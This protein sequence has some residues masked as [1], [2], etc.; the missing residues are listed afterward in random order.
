MSPLTRTVRLRDKPSAGVLGTIALGVLSCLVVFADVP[1]G[2]RMW[3]PWTTAAAVVALI[4][5][6]T[7][8]RS[9]PIGAIVA[10]VALTIVAT[11]AQLVDEAGQV[12][13]G[14][15]A[16]IAFLIADVARHEPTPVVAGIGMASLVAATVTEGL[17]DDRGLGDVVF[18]AMMWAFA[19][20]T[21][22]AIRWRSAATITRDEH[23]RAEE[24]ER[25]AREL[26]DVVAHH[27]AA[28]ALTAE[29]ARTVVDTDT[30]RVDRS[31]A[32][33]NAAAS[34]AL[35]EMHTMVS[36]LRDSRGSSAPMRLDALADSLDADEPLR[37]C[38]EVEPECGEPSAA[39]T[40][41]IHRIAQE[42]VT[43]CR[44][45]AR[46]A[47]EVAVNVRCHDRDLVVT[48][49]DDGHG[50]HSRSTLG[51]GLSGMTER[52]EILGGTCTAGPQPSG[53]WKVE[54]RVPLDRPA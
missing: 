4:A 36:I 42:A 12:S 16:I 15:F 49:V 46:D 20:S 8:R 28:I 53:G 54:A 22:I 48:V 17:A 45:H 32:A 33:I 51:F 29:G 25:I 9:R 38:V 14:H 26:H 3:Q 19:A 24:R 41:A 23:V 7:R 47:T 40:S 11:G 13:F 43:N 5:L 35:D 37:V 52:A 31:L 21:A 10:L 18:V 34:T 27:V 50:S 2:L 39:V 6:F 30:A 44:R 1:E